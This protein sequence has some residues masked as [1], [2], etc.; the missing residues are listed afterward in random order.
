MTA[1]FVNNG[2]GSLAAAVAVGD[3]TIALAAGDGAK[4]PALTSADTFYLTI[5]NATDTL[6]EIVLVTA[7]S[8]DTLTVVRAQQGTTAFTW[9]AGSRAECRV[10]A[11]DLENFG[12]QSGNVVTVAASALIDLTSLAPDTNHVVFTGTAQVSQIK[13][14]AGRSL[15]CSCATGSAVTFVN[16][17]TPYTTHRINTWTGMNLAG[18]EG[19]LFVVRALTDNFVEILGFNAANNDG[20][21]A[22]VSRVETASKGYVL[23]RALAPAGISSFPASSGSRAFGVTYTAPAIRSRVVYVVF[24]TASASRIDLTIGGFGVG[25][26]NIP[27]STFHTLCFVVPLNTTYAVTVSSGTVNLNGWYEA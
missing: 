17:A 23:D 11:A 26:W 21:G 1:K 18:M 25:T 2:V 20:F 16:T 14:K 4:F 27:T 24:N 3:T 12:R 15:I 13:L 7:R 10:T 6:R 19:V 22:G 5:C 8:G 9:P